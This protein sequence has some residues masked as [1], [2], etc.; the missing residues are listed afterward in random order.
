MTQPALIFDY[1]SPFAYLGSNLGAPTSQDLCDGASQTHALKCTLQGDRDAHVPAYDFSEA[2]MKLLRQ[3]FR[4]LG[5]ALE[6]P[7]SVYDAFSDEHRQT[8]ETHI[9]PYEGT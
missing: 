5:E 2:K 6:C 7:I 4:A 8:A 9:G 3:R 1:S